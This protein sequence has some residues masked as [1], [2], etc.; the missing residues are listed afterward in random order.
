MRRQPDWMLSEDELGQTM[1]LLMRRKPEDAV[2][3]TQ[4]SS[5]DHHK[6]LPNPF[7]VS[8]SIDVAVGLRESS[9]VTIT[10]EGRGTRYLLRT[11][12]KAAMKKLCQISQLTD[13][14]LVEVISHPTLNAVQGVVYEA[15]STDVD[16]DTLLKYLEPQGVKSVRRIIKRVNGVIRNTPLIVMTFHGTILPEIVL[17]GKLRVQVRPYYPT[18]MI[19][20][21]CGSYGH[22]KKFCG[23]AGV[24]LQCSQVHSLEDGEKCSN[25]PYCKNCE[26]SHPVTSRTCQK[27]KDEQNIIRMKIDRNISSA[28][29][30]KIYFAETTKETL[31]SE[32]QKRLD[33]S[34]S[35]KDKIIAELRAEIESLKT[36]LTTILNKEKA[37]NNTESRKEPGMAQTSTKPSSSESCQSLQRL[38]RKDQSF[39]SPPSMARDSA[40]RNESKNWQIDNERRTRSKSRKHAM[41][42]SPTD[43]N[44]KNIK[45]P[46]LP[47]DAN[48]STVE[49]DE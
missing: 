27:Y 15:D 37:K 32:V 39:K 48:G 44:F 40:R 3:Q 30:R 24:C 46:S 35:A 20:F 11:S 29:A 36:K 1:V 23:Q 4:A 17:F 5:S 13:G 38:S 2:S 33:Q 21:N 43:M 25:A 18:P 10:K 41:E 6:A 22:S 16:D 42:I 31:A 34:E 9:K 26:G 12:S 47:P 45:R 49:V 14:T 19:C 28:E 8:A 7:I